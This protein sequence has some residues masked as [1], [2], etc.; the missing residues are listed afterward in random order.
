VEDTQAGFAVALPLG[1]RV[2]DLDGHRTWTAEGPDGASYRVAILPSAGAP[3]TE[4]RLM[5]AV[6]H[7]LGHKCQPLVR[8]HGRFETDRDVA[9][10]FNARCEDGQRWRGILRASREQ[11][12]IVVE[13]LPPDV[14]ATGD[15]Y[16]YSFEYLK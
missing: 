11:L 4:K 12:V 5:E 10:R 6:L 13:V 9:E 2:D 1:A 15:A 16:Y 14:P 7:Y 3:A 8:L